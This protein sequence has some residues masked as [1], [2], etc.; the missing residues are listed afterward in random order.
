MWSRPMSRALRPLPAVVAVALVAVLLWGCAAG[1][2][3]GNDHGTAVPVT[4]VKTMD[5]LV[6][7]ALAGDR[8]NAVLFGSFA[9]LALLLAAVGIYGVLA[10]TVSQRRREIG[11]RLALGATTGDVL[12]MVVGG[13]LRLVA[14][15]VAV[16]LAG[17]L[18]LARLMES[19]LYGVPPHDPLTFVSVVVGLLAVALF[20]SWLPARRATR[21]PPAIAL[22]AE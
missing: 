6:H 20:A 13:G 14:G 17:A 21:V 5:Q 12:R 2:S 1:A 15:G 22:R 16:G 7:E 18:A 11:V 9:G 19:V 3:R 8:F 4:D 10:Y